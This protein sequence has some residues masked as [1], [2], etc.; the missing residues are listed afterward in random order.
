M[1]YTLTTKALVYELVEDLKDK[2]EIRL[3]YWN[4]INDVLT[5]EFDGE[6]FEIIDE[7]TPATQ[8]ITLNVHDVFYYFKKLKLSTFRFPEHLLNIMLEPYKEYV[9]HFD[10]MKHIQ[11]KKN[12][13]Y[14]N[15]IE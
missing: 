8:Y 2:T 3:H 12:L 15:D 4:F 6:I 11:I 14:I 5:I 13:K 10:L 7:E 1:K 9:Q